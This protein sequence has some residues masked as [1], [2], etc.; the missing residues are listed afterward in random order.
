MLTFIASLISFAACFVI[1][2]LNQSV[3]PFEELKALYAIDGP[4]GG[5]TLVY[6]KAR[7]MGEFFIVQTSTKGPIVYFRPCG[8]GREFFYFDIPKT[9][10][11]D[12]RIM[13][14]VFTNRTLVRS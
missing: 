5:T 10:I 9:W 6:G 11:G 7:S 4:L 12:M 8:N 3:T 14:E 13:E 2:L 1:Y